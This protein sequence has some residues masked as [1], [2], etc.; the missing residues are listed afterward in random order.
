[1]PQ[2]IH[3]LGGDIPRLGRDALRQVPKAPRLVPQALRLVPQAPR[4]VPQAP[5]DLR[6]LRD[7]SHVNLHQ[8][9]SWKTNPFTVRTAFYSHGENSKLKYSEKLTIKYSPRADFLYELKTTPTI[10]LK[11]YNNL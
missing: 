1:M 2:D 10:L 6:S 11:T 3:H 9:I 7:R 8:H 4:L 5:G